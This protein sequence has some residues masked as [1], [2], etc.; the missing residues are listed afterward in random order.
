VFT[1]TMRTLLQDDLGRL[2]KA[3]RDT[4]GKSPGRTALHLRATSPSIS[5]SAAARPLTDLAHDP[6]GMALTRDR[7]SGAVRSRSLRR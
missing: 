6:V 2:R 7:L 4:H 3:C 5:R 1:C